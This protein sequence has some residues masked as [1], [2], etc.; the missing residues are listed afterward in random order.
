[1]KH[2][3]L[4][5]LGLLLG[6]SACGVPDT[7][8]TNARPTVQA[9]ALPTTVAAYPPPTT[10]TPRWVPTTPT[11]NAAK[12]NTP[13]VAIPDCVFDPNAPAPTPSGRTIN[14]W[15]FSEPQTII[16]D[17]GL[18]IAQWLPDNQHILYVKQGEKQSI[19][20][21]D[22]RNNDVRSYGTRDGGIDLPVWSQDVQGIVFTDTTPEKERILKLRHSGNTPDVVLERNIDG[23]RPPQL[24]HSGKHITLYTKDTS[25]VLLHEQRGQG[26]ERANI[27]ANIRTAFDSL[28]NQHQLPTHWAWNQSEDRALVYGM[29]GQYLVDFSTNAVC[30]FQFAKERGQDT[31]WIRYGYWSPDGR[32]LALLITEG[33]TEYGLPYLK[34][35]L[36]DTRTGTLKVLEY[37]TDYIKDVHW[38]DNQ[39]LL[40]AADTPDTAYSR[41]TLALFDTISSSSRDMLA[42][43][44]FSSNYYDRDVVVSTD[45]KR[46][47]VQKFNQ[48]ANQMMLQLI[49]I[50]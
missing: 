45:R 32:Q 4:C 10:P 3:L 50:K 23:T 26:Y 18:S 49:E 17:T 8:Q 42:N 21:I 48:P 28:G 19:Q 29:N 20:T 24:S 6:L 12:S 9:T 41:Y 15:Q 35:M 2:K 46:V 34:L 25:Q 27:H 33:H 5:L 43:N 14:S 36:F 30:G 11:P 31:L 40:I 38:L 7:A 39:F 37:P 16:Q 47:I 13:P 1:M 22:V 44:Q